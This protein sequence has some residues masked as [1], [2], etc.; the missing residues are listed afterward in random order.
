M[1]NDRIT[2]TNNSNG[3]ISL[4]HV[5]TLCIDDKKILWYDLDTT[6][7]TMDHAV[8]IARGGC[9]SWTVVSAGKQQSG[10]GTHGRSWFSPDG[11]GLWVSVVLPPPLKAEYLNNLSILAARA[12]IESFKEFTELP[13]EIKYPNDVIIKGRKIAG[14][15]FESITSEQRVVSVVLGMGVNLLQTVEGFES[16]GL[17]EATSFFI[18]TGQV[19]N[20]EQFM[21]S[22]LG[23][24]KPMYENS[25]VGTVHDLSLHSSRKK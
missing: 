23:Y 9:D 10:R 3:S 20:Y 5:K 22:F 4:N 16:N 12:L 1:K 7:S 21:V 18:E 19:L 8:R 6:S 24:F 25:V 2:H 17:F 11:K 13:F 14:I 15:L